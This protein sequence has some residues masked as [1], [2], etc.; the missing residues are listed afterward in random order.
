MLKSSGL[1]TP[2]VD[3]G[4]KLLFSVHFQTVRLSGRATLNYFRHSTEDS[5]PFRYDDFHLQS[6]IFLRDFL[7]NGSFWVLFYN[8]AEISSL[9]IGTVFVGKN[10]FQLLNQNPL[11][12]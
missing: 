9:M 3:D 7:K 1:G 4:T 6:Y 5:L 8:S 10:G 12:A 11:Y 2:D